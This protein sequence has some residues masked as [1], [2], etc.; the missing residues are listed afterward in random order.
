[1]RSIQP[2]DGD[3]LRALACPWCG[4]PP[5]GA[6]LGF[7]VVRERSVVGAI[8][9]GEPVDAV[10]PPRSLAVKQ[11]W[12]APGDVREL[13]GTQLVHRAA[14]QLKAR[15]VRCVVSG[16]TAGV[17]DCSHPPAD[18]LATVGFVEHVRGVQWR[19]DLRRTVPVLDAARGWVD[20]VARVV[21]PVRPASAQR[22]R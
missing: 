13:I 1:M 11:V 8:V 19:L 6:S 14:G 21:R 20:A 7:K 18:F 17:P 16:G 9:L 4:R 15:G 2:L 3:D 12:V 5:V 22:S 10:C